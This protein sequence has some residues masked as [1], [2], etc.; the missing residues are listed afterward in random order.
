MS[1]LAVLARPVGPLVFK[2]AVVRRLAL[3]ILN[4]ARHGDRV[5]ADRL[6]EQGRIISQRSVGREAPSTEEVSVAPLALLPCPIILA[7]AENDALLPVAACGEVARERL[8]A[9][10]FEI[11]PVVHHV[12]M[13]D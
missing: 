3:R 10:A 2:S 4:S 7:C 1:R 6:L 9:V 8:P 12:P 11:L 5:P 13:F